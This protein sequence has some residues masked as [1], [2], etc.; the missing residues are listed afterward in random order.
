MPPCTPYGGVLVLNI[1]MGKTNV[2]KW[3]T[4]VTC[5][6]F[7]RQYVNMLSINHIKFIICTEAGR[8]SNINSASVAVVKRSIMCRSQ[9][10]A[11]LQFLEFPF[12]S[13]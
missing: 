3:L 7:S 13:L 9:Y 11:F 8:C 4:L 10:K 2:F 1:E 12:I 6:S 5:F